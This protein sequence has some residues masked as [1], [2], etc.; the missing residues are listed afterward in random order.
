MFIF[1]DLFKLRIGNT[2]LIQNRLQPCHYEY[3]ISINK[4]HKN[5]GVKLENFKVNVF[6]FRKST[7]ISCSL[8][9]VWILNETVNIIKERH[10]RPAGLFISKVYNILPWS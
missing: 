10:Q 5:K 1:S 4:P 3:I 2:N 9:A 8:Y 7:L 6:C